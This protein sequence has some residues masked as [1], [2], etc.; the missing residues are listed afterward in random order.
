MDA[1]IV[2]IETMGKRVVLSRE[3][4]TALDAF[5]VVRLYS[6]HFG[7]AGY[8]I[9]RSMARTLITE[10]VQARCPHEMVEG[11]FMAAHRHDLHDGHIRR[12]EET[13]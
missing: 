9:S 3:V 1:D 5:A 13:A 2:K 4:T 8:V 10:D 6:R 7:S 11:V 12:R